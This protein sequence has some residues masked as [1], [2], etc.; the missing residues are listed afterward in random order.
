MAKKSKKRK[1]RSKPR[2]NVTNGVIMPMV[3]GNALT[4]GFF[5][6][7]LRAFV[8]NRAPFGA[9]NN[10]NSWE[11]TAPEL[12]ASIMGDNDHYGTDYSFT[13]AVRYNLSKNY[14]QMLPVLF[15]AR[16]AFK[17]IEN[18]TSPL[19]RPINKALKASGVGVMV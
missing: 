1:S 10:N 6:V 2:F 8:T 3:I 12:F 11:I 19:R 17:M 16:P 9:N 5:G 14:G 18:V 4:Q 7:S 13:K 15:L